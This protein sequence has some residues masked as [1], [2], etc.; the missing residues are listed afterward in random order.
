MLIGVNLDELMVRA[1]LEACL[2]TDEE[3]AA[4]PAAWRELK[5]VFFGGRVGVQSRLQLALWE[6]RSML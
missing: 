6:M 4:G 1:T 2:L 3:Y 5:D